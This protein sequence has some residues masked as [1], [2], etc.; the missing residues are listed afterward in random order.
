MPI[1]V[2]TGC[3]R[4]LGRALVDRFIERNWTV[5]GC[6]RTVES[7][8]ALTAARA[9]PHRF[10]R[11][12]VTDAEAVAGW[13]ESFLATHGPPDMVIN[14][15]A[16]INPNA[17]LWKVAPDDFRAVLRTNIDGIYHV[18]RA[19]VPAM[20]ERGRGILINIS[21][22]WGY[23]TSPEVAPYCASK[24][25]VEGLT[26]SLAQELPAGLAA[27][28]LN[29]GV[30]DTDMLRSCFGEAA[31]VYPRPSEWSQ[32]AIDVLLALGPESNGQSVSLE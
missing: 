2:I 31:R 12:D 26:R 11:V 10:D 14:N 1:V 20:I 6:T 15:A 16:R 19:V 30:I 27:V 25:A 5:V 13:A 4:G 32:R 8:G 22:T 18:V 17:P 23:T 21:S 29:P 3:G 24:F 9:A 7:L 28:A